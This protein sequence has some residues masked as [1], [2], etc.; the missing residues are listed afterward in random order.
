VLLYLLPCLL[1]VG[2]YIALRSICSQECNPT[3]LGLQDADVSF[4]FCCLSVEFGAMDQNVL[5][6]FLSAA[7]TAITVQI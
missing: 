2:Q 1:Q 5:Y 4:Q 3:K 7:R 6:S